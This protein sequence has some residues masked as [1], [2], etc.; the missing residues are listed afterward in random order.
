MH[1]RTAESAGAPRRLETSAPQMLLGPEHYPEAGA[2]SSSHRVSP[3]FGRPAVSSLGPRREHSQHVHLKLRA[4]IPGC[5]APS[6]C[7]AGKIF[8]A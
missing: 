4:R 5:R 1:N 2:G 6:G 3:P 7:L 8:L